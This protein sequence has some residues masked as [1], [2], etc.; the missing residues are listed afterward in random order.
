[1]HL[2]SQLAA[3]IYVGFMLWL[4]RRDVRERPNVTGALW[5]PFFWV[6]I[7]GSRFISEW[8]AIFGLNW[9]GASVEEGSP[10]D[11]S[12][13]FGLIFGGLYVLNQRRVSVAE[14]VR[15]NQW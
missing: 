10:L 1:M 14:F 13:F 9:G 3:I 7:S 2:P 11:A 15:N 12:F 8:L 4:F 6:L 5:I